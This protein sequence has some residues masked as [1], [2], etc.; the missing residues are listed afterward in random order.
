MEE[1]AALNPGASRG[2]DQ[3]NFSPNASRYEDGSAADSATDMFGGRSPDATAASGFGDTMSDMTQKDPRATS[4]SFL[5]SAGSDKTTVSIKAPKPKSEPRPGMQDLV[6]IKSVFDIY[7]AVRILVG[8]IANCWS[9]AN[10]NMTSFRQ[11]M[12][13]LARV[14]VGSDAFVVPGFL[15]Q[16]MEPVLQK[17][18]SKSKGEHLEVTDPTVAVV[19]CKMNTPYFKH[20]VVMLK[21]RWLLRLHS[22]CCE[23]DYKMCSCANLIKGLQHVALQQY[24]ESESDSVFENKVS[25]HI[26]SHVNMEAVID[27]IFDQ[28]QRALGC[29]WRGFLEYVATCDPMRSVHITRTDTAT[30]QIVTNDTI[31]QTIDTI[32]STYFL[33]TER[34]LPA[35]DLQGCLDH[36]GKLG[37]RVPEL[38]PLKKAQNLRMWAK[39]KTKPTRQD[40]D[41]ANKKDIEKLAQLDAVLLCAAL[42]LKLDEVM[43]TKEELAEMADVALLP[44][45]MQGDVAPE[46][47]DFGSTGKGVDGPPDAR[48]L[49]VDKPQCS[50]VLFNAVVHCIH[51]H[52]T[53]P[54]GIRERLY[55]VMVEEYGLTREQS[56]RLAIAVTQNIDGNRL[57]QSRLVEMEHREKSRLRRHEELT[58]KDCSHL[59]VPA[60][61][62]SLFDKGKAPKYTSSTPT[63]SLS[64]PDF[65]RTL[66]ELRGFKT[67]NDGRTNFKVPMSTGPLTMDPVLRQLRTTGFFIKMPPLSATPRSMPPQEA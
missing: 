26:G 58:Y 66:P 29:G 56:E 11:V 33:R 65:S 16:D 6:R 40:R 12:P 50:P 61:V 30:P 47:V 3:T 59:M 52:M 23:L 4:S 14:H 46:P 18:T 5:K 24:A 8:M 7:K 49:L 10:G 55:Q 62:S 43:A 38:Q 60:L 44:K 27:D 22:A 21:L 67:R 28:L 9:G 51:H 31:A 15:L 57:P 17:A 37:L 36:I 45:T 35:S 19:T 41:R 64:T 25:Q 1:R 42:E 63:R 34:R 32:W 48:V 13:G 2:T 53:F 20:I 39:A 54:A